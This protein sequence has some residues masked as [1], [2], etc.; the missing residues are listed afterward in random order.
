MRKSSSKHSKSNTFW[1]MLLFVLS[2]KSREAIEE[3][4]VMYV[5]GFISMK[6]CD[7]GP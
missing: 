4:V 7:M 3:S 5:F 1:H 2:I 6:E